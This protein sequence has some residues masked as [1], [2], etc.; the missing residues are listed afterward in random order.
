M[1]DREKALNVYARKWGDLFGVLH[2]PRQKIHIEE[3]NVCGQVVFTMSAEDAE[4]YKVCGSG[5]DWAECWQ[6]LEEPT[7]AE[8]EQVKLGL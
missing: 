4:L 1:N 8:F 7:D 2:I 5:G 3:K 6:D